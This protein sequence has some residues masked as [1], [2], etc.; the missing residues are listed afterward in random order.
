MSVPIIKIEV[1][2][3]RQ[4]ML[5]AFSDHLVNLSADF[6]VAIEAACSPDK[7]QALLTEAA[8]RYLNEA[9]QTET[10][11]FFLYGEGRKLVAEHIKQRFIKDLGVT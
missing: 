2:H 10:K 3:M 8:A 7:V 4:Q 9:I 11:S 6:K 1:E 5:H